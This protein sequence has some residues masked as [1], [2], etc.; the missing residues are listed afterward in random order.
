MLKISALT[1]VTN[2]KTWNIEAYE[3][4]VY[5]ENWKKTEYSD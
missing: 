5:I 2:P 3:K 4:H 1:F